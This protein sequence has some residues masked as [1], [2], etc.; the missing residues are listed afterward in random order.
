MMKLFLLVCLFFFACQQTKKPGGDTTA[1]S[2]DS[3]KQQKPDIQPASQTTTDLPADDRSI[4][5]GESIGKTH[6]GTEASQLERL[7]G[8]PDLSDAA[9]GKA[10]LTWKGKASELNIYT[11]YKDSTMREKTVQ[12]IR[13][14]SSFFSTA[15]GAKVGTSFAAIQQLF[16]GLRKAAHY[17][18]GGRTIVIYDD[19]AEGIAIETGTSGDREICTGIIVHKKGVAAMDVYI[20]LHPDMQRY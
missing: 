12:Q 2:I 1:P 6:L 13:T 9:M 7:L 19:K 8:S 18:G 17:T 14:T 20:S 4:V 3:T 10:W 15:G 16:S 5:P 11:T